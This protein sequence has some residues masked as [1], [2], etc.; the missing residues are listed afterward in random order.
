MSSSDSRL[1]ILI[2]LVLDEDISVDSSGQC[3]LHPVSLAD[4]SFTECVGND[5]DFLEPTNSVRSK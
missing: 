4:G 5:E 3:K 2:F 1:G